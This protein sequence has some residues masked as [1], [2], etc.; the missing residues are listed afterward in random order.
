MRKDPL[1]VGEGEVVWG[2][3][4]EVW[5]ELGEEVGRPDPQQVTIIA[6]TLGLSLVV[7]HVL[8]VEGDAHIND[9]DTAAGTLTCIS[10][11]VLCRPED[12][13]LKHISYSSLLWTWR[14]PRYLYC[15]LLISP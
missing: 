13:R 3:G 14:G 12:H 2:L 5:Q 10:V 4:V 6:G 7:I 9:P 11:R 15:F 8:V 1:L